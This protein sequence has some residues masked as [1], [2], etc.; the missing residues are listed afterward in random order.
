MSC[1]QQSVPQLFG[2]IRAIGRLHGQSSMSSTGPDKNNWKITFHFPPFAGILGFLLISDYPRS[3]ILCVLYQCISYD[4]RNFAT[5]I[6]AIQNRT[7][8][9]YG[10]VWSTALI[11]TILFWA[12]TETLGLKPTCSAMLGL[13]HTNLVLKTSHSFQWEAKKLIFDSGH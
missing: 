8:K 4:P 2:N 9:L 13:R 3:I 6:H 10:S 1:S 5:L 11:T 7:W 12:I